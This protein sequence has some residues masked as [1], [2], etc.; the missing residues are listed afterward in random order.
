MR[1]WFNVDLLTQ[2]VY[3][4]SLTNFQDTLTKFQEDYYID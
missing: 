3:K 1:E 2:A 4:S